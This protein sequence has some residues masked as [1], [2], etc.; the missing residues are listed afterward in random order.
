[1][2]R[3]RRV[4]LGTLTVITFILACS[5]FGQDNN[6]PSV[7]ESA[8]SA[9]VYPKVALVLSGGGARGFAHIGAIKVIEELGI[10]IDYVVGTSMGSIVGGLYASGYSSHEIEKIIREV[11]WEDI[12]SDTPPRNLWSYQKKRTSAKYILGVG[13]DWKGGF[14]VPRGLT[15]GQKISNLMAFLTMRVSDISQF[16]RLPIPYRAVAADIV[17]GEEVVLDHG[18]LADT[19]RA[20]MSVPGLFTPITIDGH[21]LVDG[22][23]INNLPVDVAKR[24]G[25]DIVIAVDISTPLKSQEELGNPIAILNQMVGLQM[26]KATEKQRKLAD[27]V[28]IP[29]LKNYSSSSFGN[30]VEISTLGEEAAR[31]RFD[32]LRQLAEKISQTRPKSRAV[33][34]AVTQNIE[35]P[36]I[37]DVD[38][39]G[40]TSENKPLLLKQLEVYKG[41]SL[42]P[43]LL[44]Q[45]ITE[46]FSTGKYETVKFTLE[47]GSENGKILTLHL[48]D[49]KQGRNMI[50]VGLNYESRF[51]DAD[52][53]K[54][55][56]L[57]NADCNNLTGPGSSWSTD[58]Q[59]VNV[60]K[61]ESEYF[62]PLFKGFFLAPLASYSDDYQLIYEQKESVARY[63]NKETGF[64][65]RV[66]TF[67]SRI[68]EVSLGYLLEDIDAAP[69]TDAE[70]ERFAKFHETVTSITFRSRIDSLDTFP[71]AHSGGMLNID[72]QFAS[73][74]LGGKASFHRLLADYWRYFPLSDRS[75][76]GVNLRLGTDFDSDIREYKY[77]LLGGRDSFVGY[78]VEELRGAHVG[79]LTLEYR[80]KIQE[81]PSAVGGGIFATVTGN[82]GNAWKS[83][84]DMT[85]DFSLRYGGSLGIGVDTILGPI[86]ADFSMG[87]EGRRNI[88]LNIGY[89]F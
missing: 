34:T 48:Q 41:K 66:G 52:E 4:F 37:E 47:N 36:F 89:K 33:P 7:S 69:S 23:V 6:P 78:K 17:T 73:K 60:L 21:L 88:Y 5:A 50:R 45:K 28:I 87:D 67:I 39:A 25:A 16:D 9:T 58:L 79:A 30:A 76:F 54:I 63:N 57:F 31:A 49:Q 29:D 1:M 62:Q 11:D 40:S 71:F 64:G 8:Q 22:G 20:S 74:K 24:M 46:I 14:V 42:D 26:V 15:G 10:P 81:L 85:K 82:I 68:G 44:E 55:V 18:S 43:N 86:R 51:D 56:F 53:D 27:I 61:V 83:Y 38:I 2:K 12:F 72:Y 65:V 70:K 75:T 32:D 35:Q 19:M 59:F 77:F 80:Y 84:N 13:F 3:Q